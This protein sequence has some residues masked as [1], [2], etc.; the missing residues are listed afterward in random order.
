M[1]PNIESDPLA[2]EYDTVE[3]RRITFLGEEARSSL[4]LLIKERAP[5][6][7]DPLF[8]G[9]EDFENF[10]NKADVRGKALIETVNDV[11]VTLCKT[12]GDFFLEWG[13]PGRNFYKENGLPTPE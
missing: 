1:V 8:A 13:I 2:L 9:D 3:G 4:V 5:K 11:N 6:Q 12:V 7:D 10:K